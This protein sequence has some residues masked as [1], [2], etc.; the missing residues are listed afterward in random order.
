MSALAGAG[1]VAAAAAAAAAILLVPSRAR[2]IAMLAALALLPVLIAGDQ[3][4]SAAISDLR[5]S[6]SRLLALALL[7]AV[8]IAAL[9]V[10]FGRRPRLLPLAIVAAL[11]FRIPLHAGGDQANLLVPLYLVIAGGVVATALAAVA[12]RPR[13]M[14]AGRAVRSAADPAGWLPWILATIVVVYALQTLYSDDFSQGLQN[15]C[16]FVV[17]FSIAFAL[18]LEVRWD[19]R[20]LVTA[21]AIVVAEALL[22]VAVGL[23]EYASRDLLW[24]RAVIRSN[25]FH[26]YFRV[27]SLFWDPNVYGRYLALVIVALSAAVLFARERRAAT[28][29]AAAIGALWLG[30]ATTFSQ[31]SFAALLAGLAVLAALRWSL[32]WTALACAG[33]GDRRRRLRSRRGRLAEDRPLLR[34]DGQQGHRRARQPD[35]RRCRAVRRPA[36]A[37]VRVGLVLDRLPP[38]GRRQGAGNRIPHRAD[39]DRRRAGPDRPDPLSRPSR[40]WPCGR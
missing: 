18:L 9:A 27:N 35:L 13:R 34:R 11:P 3:W 15:V 38:P 39:H 16:F 23:I 4:H 5:H 25:E 8:A 31:S 6:P 36:P 33:R 26:V 17:P 19:R 20:L 40:A 28:V 21:L 37:R 14:A 32:R 10:L 7:G 2:S 22:F 1:V 12:R 24:N 29:L 30:L